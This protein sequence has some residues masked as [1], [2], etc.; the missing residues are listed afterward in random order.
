LREPHLSRAADLE[1][2]A[3]RPRPSRR[4]D[5]A[6]KSSS[7]FPLGG[8]GDRRRPLGFWLT[9]GTSCHQL[10]IAFLTVLV[11]LALALALLEGVWRSVA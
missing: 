4:L 6:T 2:R 8:G 9:E 1:A 3:I 7:R 11:T 10:A 5:A